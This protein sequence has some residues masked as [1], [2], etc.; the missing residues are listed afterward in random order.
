MKS[1][2]IAELHALSVAIV[3][4]GDTFTARRALQRLERGEITVRIATEAL[5][6]PTEQQGGICTVL[7]DDGDTVKALGFVTMYSAWLEEDV[8]DL[9]RCL[10]V[11]E[12]FTE[13]IQ[14]WPIS[15]KL[16]HAADLVRRLDSDEV[17]DLPDAL[18][19]ARQLFERRNDVVHGRIYAGHDRKDYLQSGRRHIPPRVVT[20]AELYEL[21]NQIWEYR[22]AFLGPPLFRLPRAVRGYLDAR[23]RE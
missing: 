11:V 15:R 2:T 1:A 20:S 6:Y 3:A 22:G 12:P 18:E 17:R 13:D 23:P 10:D 5:P 16:T 9:L 19:D 14:R 21:A 8:D 4:C 7:K